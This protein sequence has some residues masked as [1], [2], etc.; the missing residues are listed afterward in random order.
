MPGS[1]FV[2]ANEDSLSP[3]SRREALAWLAKHG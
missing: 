2:A 3:L 1:A